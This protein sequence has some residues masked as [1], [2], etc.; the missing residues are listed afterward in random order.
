MIEDTAKYG[1]DKCIQA[2]LNQTKIEELLG[3]FAEHYS[4]WLTKLMLERL[5]PVPHFE[6]MIDFQY[7]KNKNKESSFSMYNSILKSYEILK[8]PDK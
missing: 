6:H 3:E 1:F 8:I 2:P 4:F 5:G 7:M